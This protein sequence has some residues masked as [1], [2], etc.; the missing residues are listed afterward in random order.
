MGGWALKLQEHTR[1]V[2]SYGY[3]QN[4]LELKL[5]G[6]V[7]VINTVRE[8]EARIV[9][10]EGYPPGSVGLH[11]RLIAVAPDEW[12]KE[13]QSYG[14]GD[15]RIALNSVLNQR[16]FGRDDLWI[17]Y[18]VTANAVRRTIVLGG[19]TSRA[20]INYGYGG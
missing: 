15:G 16:A 7:E 1:A 5:N 8:Y 2:H 13:L 17:I 10:H 18:T 3:E 11:D 9:K 4:L 12:E 14:S 20:L 19:I 6:K